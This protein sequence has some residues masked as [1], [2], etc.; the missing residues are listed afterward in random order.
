MRQRRTCLLLGVLV[1]AGVLLA[2]ARAPGSGLALGFEP[3][4]EIQP[5]DLDPESV[6]I[7][8]VTGDRR[9]DVVMT[10]GAWES[11]KYS[12]KVLLYR[13]LPNG[14][15][16]APEA[17][18]PVWKVAVHGVALGDVDGD[19][20]NDVVVATELGVN[21]F[22]QRDGTL[23]RPFVIPY[24]VGGYAVDIADMNRDGRRDIVVRGGTWVR[25]ARNLRGGFRGSIVARGRNQDVDAGD[26]TGDRRPDLVAASYQGRLRVYRQRRNGTFSRARVQRTRRG[27]S[28]VSVADLTRDGRLD[29]A[30]A[31]RSSLEVLVQTANGRLRSVSVTPGIDYP[32]GI[33][34]LDL[35][36]DGKVD[37]IARAS[38]SVGVVLQQG[39][40]TFGGFDI[41]HAGSR[42]LSWHPDAIAAGDLTGDG[43]PDIAA[44]GGLARGLFVWRQV[45]P[46]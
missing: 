36:G 42:P 40:G 31:N 4:R 16:S 20:R 39:R 2:P 21:V 32:D 12:W 25:I 1:A 11:A 30:T 19:R 3:V 15:L 29:V 43:R 45:P 22:R 37:L 44:A 5:V 17:F 41:Y 23:S 26:V 13:Q 7:A 46:G 8:D 18:L 33:K 6:A 27:A 34:T 14:E 28:G 38:Q 10:T 35:S 9:N 24:T